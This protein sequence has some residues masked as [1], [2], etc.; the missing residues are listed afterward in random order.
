MLDAAGEKIPSAGWTW[1]DY[2]A[3]AKKMTKGSGA[4]KVYGSYMHTWPEFRHEGLYNSIMDNPYI[5]PNGKSNLNDPQ[6][7]EWLTFMKKM[8]DD[9]I[10]VPYADAKSTNIDY[11]QE[12]LQGKTGMMVTG[13]WLLTN[14]LDTEKY[15]HDFDTV[16]APF[17]VWK[18][19]KAGTTQGGVSYQTVGKNSKHP[20]EAYE[21]ARYV[22][23]KGAVEGQYKPA[24]KNGDIKSVITEMVGKK[25]NLFDVKSLLDVWENP[26]ITLNTITREPDKYVEIDGIFDTET[27]K[28]MLGDQSV[29]QTMDNIKKQ[30]EPIIAK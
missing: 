20:K 14:I 10:Q 30:A 22:S 26:N 9:G 2:A 6:F 1:D 5:K 18:D 17:P 28:F 12:F 16:V 29:K 24:T 4:N 19:G 13:T 15:P 7:A 8:E 11:N 21:F 23:G 27:Q 3:L 25:T